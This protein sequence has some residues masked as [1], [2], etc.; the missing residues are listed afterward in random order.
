MCAVRRVNVA[1]ATA[2][3]P[4]VS[5]EL[6]M[7]GVEVE[8][9]AELEKVELQ[10]KVSVSVEALYSKI[11]SEDQDHSAVLQ[12]NKELQTLLAA[13]VKVRQELLDD[14][15]KHTNCGDYLTQ[16]LDAHQLT[17]ELQTARTSTSTAWTVAIFIRLMS[18][19]FL[20]HQ[21]IVYT[22]K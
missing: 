10:D 8:E 1:E 17:Q 21:H 14:K 13:L 19:F 11:E 5:V 9:F 12:L 16:E 7:V 15:D 4:Q 3:R 20:G 18:R 6:K 2:K 22:I